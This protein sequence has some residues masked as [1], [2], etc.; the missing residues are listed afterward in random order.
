MND[1]MPA[2]KGQSIKCTQ[3]G[4]YYDPTESAG[5]LACL[6]EQRGTDTPRR[7]FVSPLLWLIGLSLTGWGGYVFI[8]SLAGRAQRIHDAAVPVES[9]I[10]PELVRIRL[11]AVEALVYGDGTG[12][13]AYGTRI[14]RATMQLYSSVTVRAPKLLATRYGGRLVGFA[15]AASHEDAEYQN[16]DMARVRRDWEELRA[17][18]FRDASWFR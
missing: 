12:E 11:E 2:A 13:I 8:G 1:P 10:D 18:V 17:E 6:K 14:Q 5:C 7:S 3:H 16:I 4:F 9:H 15:N